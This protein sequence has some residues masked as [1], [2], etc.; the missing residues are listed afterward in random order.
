MRED[1]H[2]FPRQRPVAG[3][4]H[5]TENAVQGAAR[6]PC[7]PDLRF[8]LGYEPNLWSLTPNQKT[9]VYPVNLERESGHS[10][11]KIE[12]RWVRLGGRGAVFRTREP[13]FLSPSHAPRCGAL[14]TEGAGG[15]ESGV[16]G[17]PEQ[18]RIN[19]LPAQEGVATGLQDG[20]GDCRREGRRG[21]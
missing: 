17:S 21:A 3:T 8:F 7:P 6:A 11:L 13:R 9:C 12:N 5:R 14:C 1:S 4:K 15:G 18:V 2:A 19:R 10:C 20:N 16:L